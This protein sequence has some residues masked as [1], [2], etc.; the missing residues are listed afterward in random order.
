MEFNYGLLRQIRTRMGYTQA[1]LAKEIGVARTTY[2]DY[3]KGNIT[4]TLE[5][6]HRICEVCAIDISDLIQPEPADTGLAIG[7]ALHE[8]GLIVS[9]A[10]MPQEDK[11]II[12]A[13]MKYVYEKHENSKE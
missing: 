8:A 9:R 10:T 12:Y 4:P 7:K 5:R 13:L 11:N 3:E 6:L 2:A 1:E